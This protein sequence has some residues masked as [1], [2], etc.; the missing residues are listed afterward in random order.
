MTHGTVEYEARDG[1][2]VRARRPGVPRRWVVL[3][4]AAAA[5]LVSAWV[6]Y[7]VRDRRERVQNQYIPPAAWLDRKVSVVESPRQWRGV[8][9]A[10]PGDEVWWFRSPPE[11]WQQLMGTAGQCLVRDGM[12]IDGYVTMVN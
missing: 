9:R 2:T 5:V 3:A 6:A 1:Q 10:K 7:R 11:S 4:V 8:V 12:P